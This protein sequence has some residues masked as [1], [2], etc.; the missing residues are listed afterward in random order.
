MH[1]IAVR[2]IAALIA[3]GGIVA[4]APRLAAIETTYGEDPVPSTVY[5]KGYINLGYG[6]DPIPAKTLSQRW[7]AWRASRGLGPET[8]AL[9]RTN[10]SATRPQTDKVIDSRPND[11][12]AEAARGSQRPR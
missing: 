2:W 3:A 7:H 9:S 8:R 5:F 4:H 12:R 1:R 6:A 11:P 10:G